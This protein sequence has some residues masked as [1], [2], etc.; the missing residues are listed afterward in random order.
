MSKDYDAIVVGGRCAGSPTARLLAQKGYR[1]LVV[2]RASFPSDT[3]ST[4]VIHATG[5]AALRR[6]GLLDAVTATGCPPINTYAFD[7]GPF[8]T[9][10]A[11]AR[12]VPTAYAPRRT[13]LDKILLDAAAGR[14]RGAGGLHRRGARWSRTA[15]V[16][17]RGHASDG[18]R[19]T[20]GP[21]WCRRRRAAPRRGQRR[22]SPSSTTTSRC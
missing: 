5:V 3:L 9:G 6:W 14:G 4:L 8:I 12:R 13:V 2:D 15:V 19:S 7:F 20:S 17:I 22:P 10:P 18:A 16:G 1:V 21:G 11:P